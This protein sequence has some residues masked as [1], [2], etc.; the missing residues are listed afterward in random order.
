MVTHSSCLYT[1]TRYFSFY[2]AQGKT[3]ENNFKNYSS[4]KYYIS[5]KICFTECV[6]VTFSQSHIELKNICQANRPKLFLCLLRLISCGDHLEL[7]KFDLIADLSKSNTTIM[8]NFYR[9]TLHNL[10]TLSYSTFSESK[11]VKS[12]YL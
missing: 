9:N 8:L 2:V 7:K 4:L 3:G 6:W 10:Y 5:P 1:T 11:P 12:T